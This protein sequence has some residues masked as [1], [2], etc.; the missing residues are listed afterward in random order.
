MG[1]K[2][3]YGGLISAGGGFVAATL[4][5]SLSQSSHLPALLA[6]ILCPAGL[7]G[8][9]APTAA[10]DAGLLWSV[11]IANAVIYGLAGLTCGLFFRVDDN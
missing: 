6:F 4:T 3:I 10:P 2:T 5:L 11:R 7:I 9:L 1:K 8:W